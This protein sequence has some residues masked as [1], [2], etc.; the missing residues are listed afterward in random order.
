[1][2]IDHPSFFHS[3][4]STRDDGGFLPDG[5]PSSLSRSVGTV[6]VLPGELGSFL[7]DGTPQN[8]KPGPSSTVGI[9][10]NSSRT[11]GNKLRPKTKMAS[12]SCKPSEAMI[13]ISQ[14]LELPIVCEALHSKPEVA[15][16]GFPFLSLLKVHLIIVNGMRGKISPPSRRATAG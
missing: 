6:F 1:M 13:K 12:D 14:L 3:L 10:R 15:P 5:E 11:N 4:C 9:H 16:S 7:S 2:K 8:N